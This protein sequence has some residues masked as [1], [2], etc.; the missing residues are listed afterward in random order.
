M[1]SSV[2]VSRSP[3]AILVWRVLGTAFS[4]I[5][6]VFAFPPHDVMWLAPIAVAI[7][8]LSWH[9]ARTL[10][11]FWLG[12][13]F[14]ACFFLPH[15]AW[16]RVV[17]DDAWVMLSALFAPAFGLLGAGVAITSR[18][19]VW[20]LAVPLMW[21]ATEALRDRFPFNGFPWG[22]LAFSQAS[23]PLASYSAIAGAPLVTLIVALIGS[24]L[25]TA[26]IMRRSPRL[27][28]ACLIGVALL[29]T[30]GGVVPIATGGTTSGGPASVTA[31]VVQG[32][33][34]GV[35]LDF[36]GQREAVL[37]NHVKETLVLAADV[38]AGKTRQPDLVVWPENSSDIDPL[39]DT[40]AG[41]LIQTAVD[42]IGVPILVG[43]VVN[44]PS[45]PEHIWNA[46]IV[47]MPTNSPTPGPTSFYVK[48]HPVPFGEYI[49]MRS[50]IS[51][52]TDRLDRIPRDF[53]AGESTGVLQLGPARI[54][55]L[56][57]FEVAYDELAR[58]ATTGA[59]VIGPLAGQGARILTIQTNNATYAHTGQP[60]QQLAMSR[61]RAIE[62]SRTV[63]IASTS[64]VSAI[65]EPDGSYAGVIGESRPGYLVAQVPLRDDMTISDQ[66][67]GWPEALAVLL[68]LGLV[69]AAALRNRRDRRVGSTITTH[70][71]PIQELAP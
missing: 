3:R 28:V 15:I 47:W 59:G 4:G 60:E 30:A 70:V 38:K 8:T 48:Q 54:G 43:A 66:L 20:P 24:L 32:S 53:A 37:Q 17:G 9:G 2:H 71:D 33:V 22:R 61:L 10:T 62:H 23:S 52:V 13:L 6:M 34:P 49:P 25:A 41:D 21:V 57:C 26:W 16:M 31:A 40:Q 27:S 12:L 39:V 11:G 45:D 65:I 14:A 7:A 29:S 46:G 58:A 51:H 44:A 67:G 50:L 18:L 36:L 55:D 19:R 35:G 42:A 1:L 5:L 56:I 69:A 64:G 63:L 68:A